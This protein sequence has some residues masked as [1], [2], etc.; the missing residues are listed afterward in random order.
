VHEGHVAGYQ[1]LKTVL[2]DVFTRGVQFVSVYAFSTENWRRNPTEVNHLMRLV[3][4]ALHDDAHIFIEH[5]IRVKVV[6]S[7]D[8]LSEKVLR[9][10]DEIEAATE[11]LT[12]GQVLICLNYG[13]QQEILDAAKKLADTHASGGAITVELFEQFLYAPE[14]PACDMIVRT[15]GDRRLSNFMLWRGAYSEL[16]FL[17]KFWPDMTKRDVTRILKEYASR[18]RRFG[19]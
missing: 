2:L 7:R 16:L 11:H 12:D 14:V 1:A 3:L 18:V 13:G 10:I 9:A 8:R 15:G 6:G 17:K 5:N 19:G 4:R